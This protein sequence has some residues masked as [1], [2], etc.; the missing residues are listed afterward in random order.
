[1]QLKSW[2]SCEVLLNWPHHLLLEEQTNMSTCKSYHNINMSAHC[3]P[4]LLLAFHSQL[5]SSVI[6]IL[7]HVYLSSPVAFNSP[8]LL[9]EPASPGDSFLQP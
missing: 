1:L 2:S 6:F 5:P 3:W 4:V 7:L 8:L 9:M